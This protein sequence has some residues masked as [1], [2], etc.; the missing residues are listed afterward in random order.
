MMRSRVFLVATALGLMLAASCTSE[1]ESKKRRDTLPAAEDPLLTT[2]DLPPWASGY[3]FTYFNGDF[4]WFHIN[5]DGTAYAVQDGG[6]YGSETCE[7]I[8]VVAGR[9]TVPR[10][11]TNEVDSNDHGNGTLVR[12]V[13]GRYF[14]HAR[15]GYLELT[16]EDLCGREVGGCGGYGK[17]ETCND[18]EKARRIGQWRACP[19]ELAARDAGADADAN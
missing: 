3:T 16:R 4:L 13:D 9:V 12:T 17:A 14:V 18:I 19:G 11:I 15:A 7:Q 8:G 2:T 10:L 6:D 1:D 5:P